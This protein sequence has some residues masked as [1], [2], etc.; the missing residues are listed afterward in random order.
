[1]AQ[2]DFSNVYAGKGCIEEK[3]GKYIFKIT[4]STFFQT[5]TKQCEILFNKV[6][7]L[8][9][10]DKSENVLDLYSGC[11]PISL[12]ISD[13]V[14]KVF[15]VE[16]SN[17]SILSAHENAELNNVTNCDF[18]A[19]DV[20]DYLG[21]LMNE[22]QNKYDT[23]IL[24]PPRSGIHPKA[25][26][27]LCEYGAKKI[28][29]VSCNPATQARDIKLMAGKYEITAM[30]PVDMFPHTFHIENVVRLDLKS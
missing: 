27:Y 1:V 12:Y 29:Y 16:L 17:E 22:K 26:E 6:L 3:L 24:D 13:Y 8:G 5:N 9:K 11:G 28:I 2:S 14:N 23:I 19:Y 10:F 25:A 7:E 15:G 30:Q 20:K 21:V 4:P 18:A